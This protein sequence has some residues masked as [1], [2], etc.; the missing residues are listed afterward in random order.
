MAD[1]NELVR[2][3]ICLAIG[4]TLIPTPELVRVRAHQAASTLKYRN[5]RTIQECARSFEQGFAVE[6]PVFDLLCELFNPLD[7]TVQHVTLIGSPYDYKI[8]I[9]DE[10]I[11]LDVKRSS[12]PKLSISQTMRE[13]EATRNGFW[14]GEPAVKIHDV[15][16]ISVVDNPD[17]TVKLVNCFSAK[18]QEWKQNKDGN[19]SRY[20]YPRDI[21]QKTIHV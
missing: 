15:L 1:T 17:G 7:C 9:G 11:L 2:E 19:G 6:G 8:H 3:L 14:D 5:G 18:A 21:I 13:A 10:V 20:I 16:I 12:N 4:T